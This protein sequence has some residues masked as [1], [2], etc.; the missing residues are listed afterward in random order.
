MRITYTKIALLLIFGIFLFYFSFST[1]QFAPAKCS[2]SFSA[3]VK[4]SLSTLLTNPNIHFVDFTSKLY[5]NSAFPSSLFE[6]A[7]GGKKIV[8][9]CMNSPDLVCNNSYLSV[10]NTTF[11]K[12]NLSCNNDSCSIVLTELPNSVCK[13]DELSSY[14]FD[15]SIYFSILLISLAFILFIL[16]FFKIF[17]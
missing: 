17:R 2:C 12:A 3:S 8:Y 14:L 7:S 1:L 6:L 13:S 16:S 10:R 11:V 4:S 15:F 5:K 9:E